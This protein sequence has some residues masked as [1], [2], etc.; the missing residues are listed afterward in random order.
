M[1]LHLSSYKNLSF[2]LGGEFSVFIPSAHAQYTQALNAK[3]GDVLILGE[4]QPVES[5]MQ[6]E[7][8]NPVPGIKPGTVLII[9][10]IQCL[11]HAGVYL[12]AHNPI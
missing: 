1:D 6:L 9:S 4:E 7:L 2:D 8:P 3:P 11:A 12:H 10:R 5:F